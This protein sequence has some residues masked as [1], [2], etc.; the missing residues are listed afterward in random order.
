MKTTLLLAAIISI[1]FSKIIKLDQKPT[2]G[3][4]ETT[5]NAEG[6]ILTLEAKAESILLTWKCMAQ[7]DLLE[8]DS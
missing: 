7:E 6:L 5:T 4:Q 1:T 2:F 3:S 8:D